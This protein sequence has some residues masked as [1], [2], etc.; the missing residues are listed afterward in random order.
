MLSGL[1]HITLTV[2]NLPR[3]TEF[4]Q[5]IGFDL[6]VHWATGAYL[7]AGTC[8]L[9]LSEGLPKPSMDYSH[10][11]FSISE[12]SIAELKTVLARFAVSLWQENSSEGDSVYFYDLDGHKLEAH[13]GTLATRLASLKENP[14]QGLTWHK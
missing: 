3:A 8:W 2:A 13:V 10:I 1:N 5:A 11:A 7:T 12:K 4:Y 14:Y 6:H 9:C